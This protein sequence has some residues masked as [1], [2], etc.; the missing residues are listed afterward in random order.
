MTEITPLDASGKTRKASCR[1]MRIWAAV[2]AGVTV[3][4][5]IV[6]SIQ[7]RS[8][9][10]RADRDRLA[11]IKRDDK[12][13]SDAAEERERREAA[14]QRAREDYESRQVV[15]SVR[16]ESAASGNQRA[17]HVN[18]WV[19]VSTP[20]SYPIKCVDGT[21]V[22]TTTDKLGTVGYG[23]ARDKTTVDDSRTSYVF[24][25]RLSSGDREA[26]PIVRFID[27]HGSLYYQFRHYTER[28]PQNTDFSEAAR[29]IEEWM[30]TG[31]KPD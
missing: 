3:A 26:E 15:V 31:P 4:A 30:G 22:R 19:T 29:K 17:A 28:F 2:L 20:H 6:G 7:A 1:A 21:W 14:E 11:E 16:D 9:R 13:R 5:V 24:S 8:D 10:L 25:A 18:R 27:W 23:F 12:L